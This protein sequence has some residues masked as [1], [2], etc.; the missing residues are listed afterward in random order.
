[1]TVCSRELTPLERAGLLAWLLSAGDSFTAAE[2]ADLT[3]CREEDAK[4]VLERLTRVIPIYKDAGIYQA[5]TDDAGEPTSNGVAHRT[6][7]VRVVRARRF[8]APDR[9]GKY[10][11]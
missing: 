4:R 1:M 10:D 3:D 6:R 2:A 8:R 7:V 9:R 11:R 5:L